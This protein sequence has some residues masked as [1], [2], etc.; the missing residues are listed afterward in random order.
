[1]FFT[2]CGDDRLSPQYDLIPFA[3]F[4]KSTATLELFD[5]IQIDLQP[6]VFTSSIIPSSSFL[7]ALNLT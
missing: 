7:N 6:S 3:S 4:G 1:M 2:K 5:L